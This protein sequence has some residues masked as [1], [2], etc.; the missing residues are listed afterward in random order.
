MYV[1]LNSKLIR[2]YVK[3]SVASNVDHTHRLN[4]VF[5]HTYVCSYICIWKQF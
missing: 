1:L 5:I 3:S 4:C 2:K